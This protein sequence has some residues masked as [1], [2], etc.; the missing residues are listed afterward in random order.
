VEQVLVPA[1]VMIGASLL[2]VLAVPLVL[3]VVSGTYFARRWAIRLVP[4]VRRSVVD[5]AAR[6]CRSAAD[7]SGRIVHSRLPRALVIGAVG[8]VLGLPASAAPGREAAAG[9]EAM[10][11]T[12]NG[13]L[14]LTQA[15][16][17]ARPAEEPPANQVRA[18]PAG[19]R[20]GAARAVGKDCAG[21]CDLSSQQNGHKSKSKKS[22]KNKS[23]D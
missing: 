8:C 17:V 16:P 5:Q 18:T 13:P 15:A 3:L 23:D 20:A 10:P 9:L 2:V 7:L 12:G 1:L 22:K 6:T 21:S 11:S 19:S 14:R 4:V